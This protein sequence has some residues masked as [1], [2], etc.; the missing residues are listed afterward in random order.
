MYDDVMAAD[1]RSRDLGVLV[2]FDGSDH[3][4]AALQFGATEAL[5]R[6]TVLTVVTAYTVPVP[7][8]PNMASLPPEPEDRARRK[9]AEATLDAAKEFLSDYTGEVIL[10]V[11][12]GNPTGT[13]ADLSR[14]AQLV[15]VGARG[16][17]GFVGRV[18]GS[19]ASALPAH[20]HCPTIVFPGTDSAEADAKPE[21]FVDQKQ[22]GPVV[23]AIDGSAQS[24]EVLKQAAQAAEETAAELRILMIMPL[25]EEWLYW[26]PDVRL[27]NESSQRRKNE[28]E[29]MIRDDHAWLFDEHPDLDIS[30]DV[31][32]GEPMIVIADRTA[33]ARL[34]VV[35]S[36]GRGAVRSVLLGSVSR[37]VLNNAQGAVMIV[38]RKSS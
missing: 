23:V 3:A 25:M 12:E 26:Y 38:P 35:G 28:L 31:E 21:K 16:R 19:V 6:K 2:G 32:I 17:G 29:K 14:R 13:L 10:G 11:A 5:R 27:Q 7:V 18:L 15:I 33:T 36:R 20:A 1:M 22:D 8:Y 24:T 34:T 30:I 9:L 4:K 37:G